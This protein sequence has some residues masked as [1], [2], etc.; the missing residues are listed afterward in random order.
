MILCS[1]REQNEWGLGSVIQYEKFL[2]LVNSFFE[3]HNKKVIS[4]KRGNIEYNNV[5][6]IFT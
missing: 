2:A 5:L 6:S 1:G 3:L 4:T